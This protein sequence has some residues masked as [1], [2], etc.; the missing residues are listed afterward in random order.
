MLGF[1]CVVCSIRLLKSWFQRYY[2]RKLLTDDK[3]LRWVNPS[4]GINCHSGGTVEGQGPWDQ[5]AMKRTDFLSG[6][7]CSYF[8]Y[9]MCCHPHYKQKL[10][11]CSWTSRDVNLKKSIFAGKPQHK[12]FRL[13]CF[14]IA[15]KDKLW[16]ITVGH[17][18]SSVLTKRS[19]Y[20]LLMS[21]IN[22]G[23]GREVGSGKHIVFQTFGVFLLWD[24]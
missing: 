18:S 6:F 13:R 5:V 14:I 22:G 15:M 20:F 8:H 11:A 7:P 9:T 17:S 24:C 19:V 1:G 16:R 12:V 3:S 10:A 4:S 2:S 23:S 21:L